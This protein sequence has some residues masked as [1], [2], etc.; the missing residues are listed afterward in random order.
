MKKMLAILLAAALASPA[1]LNAAPAPWY[2]WR[3]KAN[4]SLVC[5][6]TALGEGWLRFSG[7]YRDARCEF[8]IPAK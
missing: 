3:S 4:G 1:L 2:Q 5:S 6:Q 7:P 8:R